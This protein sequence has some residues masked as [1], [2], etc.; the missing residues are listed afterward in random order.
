MPHSVYHITINI[1]III[2]AYNVNYNYSGHD[3]LH[4]MFPLEL[5]SRK[6]LTMVLRHGCCRG[7]C[8]QAQIS[9]ICFLLLLQSPCLAVVGV[10]AL[11]I[12]WRTVV[13]GQL[14]PSFQGYLRVTCLPLGMSVSNDQQIKGYNIPVAL[15][16]GRASS[17]VPLLSRSPWGDQAET[18]INLKPALS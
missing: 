18:K 17:V 12:F 15:S 8:N 14:D 4:N 11:N 16:L 9:G 7:C 10:A 5:N 13:H 6:N 2:I 3:C 1:I